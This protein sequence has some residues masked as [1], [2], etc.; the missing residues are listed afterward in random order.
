MPK[1][2]DDDDVPFCAVLMRNARGYHAHQRTGRAGASVGSPAMLVP[3]AVLRLKTGAIGSYESTGTGLS[4]LRAARWPMRPAPWYS[5][6][7]TCRR[8]IDA[9]EASLLMGSMNTAS[10]LGPHTQTDRGTCPGVGL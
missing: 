8:R 7:K 1:P 5:S 3:L 6:L 10:K 2:S 4:S 9:G